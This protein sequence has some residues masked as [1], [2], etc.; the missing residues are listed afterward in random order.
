MGT[1]DMVG[2]IDLPPVELVDVVTVVVVKNYMI[3]LYFLTMEIR[4]KNSYGFLH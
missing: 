2:L 1:A 4:G 3:L